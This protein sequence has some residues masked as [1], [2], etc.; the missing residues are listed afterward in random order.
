MFAVI[1][2][3]SPH[4]PYQ[5]LPSDAAGFPDLNEA[6]AKHYGEL[7]ALDRSVGTLR[8]KLRELQISDNT[9]LVFCSD[10][11]GLPGIKPETVGGLRGHKGSVFE[12]GLRV[13]GIIEW[14]GRIKPRVT[15]YPACTM[16]LFP[17]IADIVGLSEKTFVLPLD[18][19]SLKP[20]LTGE[21]ISR[22]KPIPFRFGQKIALIDNDYKLLSENRKSGLFQLYRLSDD[23]AESRDL[24]S[25]Q[26]EVAERM[27]RQLLN[28]NAEVDASF[29]GADYPEKK[30]VPP[31]PPSIPWYESKEYQEYLPAWKDRWEFKSYFERVSK[32]R[33]N[34]KNNR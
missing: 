28:W 11:G 3:G 2:F 31:D 23:P 27:K 24:S 29:N 33:A 20:L 16:D 26:P 22:A 25:Q 4:S 5:A 8:A 10:N 17:T 34:G 9:L 1:W 18:G 14:P 30:V 12:G 13:P 7:V 15:E 32:Q 21:I 6:S 19:V